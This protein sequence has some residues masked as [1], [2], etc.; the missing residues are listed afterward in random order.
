MLTGCGA[1]QEVKRSIEEI[2]RERWFEFQSGPDPEERV[3][4][5]RYKE[6]QPLDELYE[7]GQITHAEKEG[8]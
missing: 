3:E 6:E 2:S 1:R 7:N 8:R 4:M 5:V